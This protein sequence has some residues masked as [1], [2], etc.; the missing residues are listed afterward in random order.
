MNTT[1][2]TF[3][4]LLAERADIPRLAYIHVVSCITD[5]AFKLY[6]DSNE[7]FTKPVAE[8]LEGQIGDPTWHHVKAVD[9][10]SG[11]LAAWASWQMPSDQQVRER[12]AKL[13]NGVQSAIPSQGTAKGEFD[14]P[15]G[16]AVHVKTDVDRFV[17]SWTWNRR[18]VLLKALFTD[19]PFQRRGMGTA[20][21]RYGNE[22]ADRDVLPIILHAS[23]YGWPIYMKQ[24]FKTVH[25]LDIDLARWAPG[26]EGG[27]KGYENYRFRYMIRLPETLK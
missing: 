17:N 10:E 22:R 18:H 21:V 8:M 5:N 25:H 15:P 4:I 19:P 9:R 14:F 2:P 27:D 23:A 3:D 6:F 11:T 16:L 12:D 13:K 24:G 7:E 26:A 20:M 1:S